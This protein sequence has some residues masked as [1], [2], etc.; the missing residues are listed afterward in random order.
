MYTSL[1]WVINGLDN[2]LSS[3]WH[4]VIIKTI[5]GFPSNTPQGN[6][7]DGKVVEAKQFQIKSI[8]NFEPLFQ[9]GD[10]LIIYHDAFLSD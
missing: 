9:R 5:N 8:Y 2:G 10:C 1:N 4:P 6:N 7:F 3:V